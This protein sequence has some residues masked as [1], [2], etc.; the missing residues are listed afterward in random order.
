MDA[1]FYPLSLEQTLLAITIL[2]PLK[3][4]IQKKGVAGRGT[5]LLPTSDHTVKEETWL[6]SASKIAAFDDRSLGGSHF[7]YE[8]HRFVERQIG[9][10]KRVV[11]YQHDVCI[12]W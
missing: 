1:P 7:F 10:D 4:D 3:K 8:S 5:E 6:S 9:Q 12:M 11:M 2:F